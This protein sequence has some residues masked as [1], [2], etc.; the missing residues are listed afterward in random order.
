MMIGLGITL[1]SGVIQYSDGWVKW[2]FPMSHTNIAIHFDGFRAVAHCE[3]WMSYVYF[4]VLIAVLVLVNWILTKK[5]NWG[6]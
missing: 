1:L 6:D 3:I 5:R 2:L 4:G